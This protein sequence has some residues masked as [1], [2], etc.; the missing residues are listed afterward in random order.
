MI[1]LYTANLE[2]HSRSLSHVVHFTVT[3]TAL[4]LV[5]S[6]KI[7]GRCSQIGACPYPLL[8]LYD[9]SIL[10]ALRQALQ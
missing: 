7:N 3:V 1:A 9:R 10:L 5:E 6:N 2:E 4:G 8:A